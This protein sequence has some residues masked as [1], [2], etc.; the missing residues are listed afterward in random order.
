MI[1][2]HSYAALTASSIYVP[3]SLILLLLLYMINIYI[4]L[5]IGCIHI[6]YINV[7]ITLKRDVS[8]FSL[9]VQQEKK[10]K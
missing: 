8:I 5:F 10:L 7:P 6:R 4:N 2:P 3:I 1:S 9:E